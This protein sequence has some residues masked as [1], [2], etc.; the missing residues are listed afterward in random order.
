MQSG[1]GIPTMRKLS[2]T[3]PELICLMMSMLSEYMSARS[4]S[5]KYLTPMEP[6]QWGW[7]GRASAV[8]ESEPSRNMVDTGAKGK[9]PVVLRAV[10]GLRDEIGASWEFS[11]PDSLS[12]LENGVETQSSLSILLSGALQV[13]VSRECNG[14]V[15]CLFGWVGLCGRMV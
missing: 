1:G 13:V 9:R 5:G 15:Y 7:R 8:I 2:A 11:D 14:K 12:E 6:M 4:S 10:G 3:S